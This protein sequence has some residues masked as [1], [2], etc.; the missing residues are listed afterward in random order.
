MRNALVAL[1]LFSLA[2]LAPACVYVEH[3]GPPPAAN[4]APR[5]DSAEAGCYWEPAVGD[6]L[7]YFDAFT[8]DPDGWADVVEVYADVYDSWSGA[9]VDSFELYPLGRYEWYT[10][11]PQHQTY[12][13]CLYPD[14]EVDFSAY[15]S[16]GAMDL[17]TVYPY[18][19]P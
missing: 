5:V 6:Y 19:T 3:D 7:W 10:D 9:W 1:S 18:Q 13:D 17:V 12:L 8:S 2:S 14:Y 15:D 4:H 16:W 11:W